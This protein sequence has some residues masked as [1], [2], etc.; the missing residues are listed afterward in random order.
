MRCECQHYWKVQGAAQGVAGDCSSDT[1]VPRGAGSVSPWSP[2]TTAL[3][4][5][6]ATVFLLQVKEIV[7]KLT[8]GSKVKKTEGGRLL[9][10]GHST[11]GGAKVGGLGLRGSSA[12][13]GWVDTVHSGTVLRRK[14]GPPLRRQAARQGT[15]PG[16][17]V[18]S[19]EM[20]QNGVR[21]GSHIHP[22]LRRTRQMGDRTNAP[23]LENAHCDE[24]EARRWGSLPSSRSIDL[25]SPRPGRPFPQRHRCAALCPFN[26]K[27]MLS[28]L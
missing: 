4:A 22:S 16:K 12:H 27:H 8:F 17:S 13:E 10:S 20:N 2:I 6:L 14:G 11:R 9:L 28:R 5:T 7:Q 23:A 15:T 21:G 19:Q 1:L 3:F 25:C 24:M 18:K 26:R